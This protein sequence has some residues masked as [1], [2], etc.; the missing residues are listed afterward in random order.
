MLVADFTQAGR[1]QQEVPARRRWESEPA[2]DEHSEKVSTG[3]Q[4]HVSFP[5]CSHPPNHP[6]GPLSNLVRGLPVGAAVAEQMPVRTLSVDFRAGATFVSA[7]VPFAQVG[8]DLGCR[9]E[10]RQLARSDSPLYR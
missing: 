8:I 10:R 2:S 6:V 1:A 4:Q 3:K 9:T 5:D 7:I